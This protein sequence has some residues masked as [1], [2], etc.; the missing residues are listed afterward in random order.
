MA[1]IGNLGARTPWRN[2]A[3]A[4]NAPSKLAL[5]AAAMAS[6]P[7]AARRC[8]ACT[9]QL[10]FTPERQVTSYCPHATACGRAIG[11]LRCSASIQRATSPGRADV[12]PDLRSALPAQQQ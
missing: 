7:S 12:A 8:T 6:P 2:A 1:C 3:S 11:C 10:H 9:A 4:A 5:E